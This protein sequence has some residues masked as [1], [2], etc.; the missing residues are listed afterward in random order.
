MPARRD[1]Q[2]SAY[3]S[4]CTASI[5]SV[6][7]AMTDCAVARKKKIYY[8]LFAKRSVAAIESI[9]SSPQRAGLASCN[10]V[11]ELHKSAKAKTAHV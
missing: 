8:Q 9:R 7:L 11:V 4:L 6:S 10:V 2:L 5:S 3:G 1:D